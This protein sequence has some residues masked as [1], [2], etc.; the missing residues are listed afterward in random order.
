MAK[1]TAKITFKVEEIQFALGPYLALEATVEG[2][3][4][5]PTGRVEFRSNAFHMGDMNLDSNGK[6]TLNYSGF[7]AETYQLVAAYNGSD[8]YEPVTS[9][10]FEYTPSKPTITKPPNI[11]FGAS[12]NQP[13]KINRETRLVEFMVDLSAYSIPTP[14][15]SSKINLDHLTATRKINIAGVGS[16]LKHGHRFFLPPEEAQKVYRGYKEYL[17]VMSGGFR[18]A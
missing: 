1:K 18:E 9:T 11:P 7:R 4:S 5:V 13:I 16:D 3:D 6:G 17:Q 8:E 12:S 15:A 10:V 2:E 14:L